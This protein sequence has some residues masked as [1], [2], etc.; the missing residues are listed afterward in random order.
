MPAGV[1][2]RVRLDAGRIVFVF[3]TI[4]YQLNTLMF[5]SRTNHA[6]SVNG[7]VPSGFLLVQ[8]ATARL[9]F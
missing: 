9:E 5:P 7:G 3:V 4:L 2:G 6:S 8:K 1:L